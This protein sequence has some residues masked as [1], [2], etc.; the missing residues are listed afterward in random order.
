MDD[1]VATARSW[2]RLR[3][4]SQAVLKEPVGKWN[5]EVRR[6]KLQVWPTGSYISQAKM[7]PCYLSMIS[8]RSLRRFDNIALRRWALF[9]VE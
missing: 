8:K 1:M 4:N 3:Q 9:T 7:S 6:Q 2:E 5:E